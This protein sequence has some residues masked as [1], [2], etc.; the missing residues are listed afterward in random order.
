MSL[1]VGQICIMC[2]TAAPLH[3]YG[4]TYWVY[5]MLAP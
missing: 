1:A 5:L 2:Q 3:A 4:T